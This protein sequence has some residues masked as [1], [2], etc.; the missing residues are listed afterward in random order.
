MQ[1]RGSNQNPKKTNTL[2]ENTKTK[3]EIVGIPEI[4]S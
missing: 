2:V 3:K 4:D 1:I